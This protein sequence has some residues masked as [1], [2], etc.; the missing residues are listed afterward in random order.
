MF[1]W[2]PLLPCI[3]TP[4]EIENYLTVV[5]VTACIHFFE[6]N[7]ICMF[8]FHRKYSF[9]FLNFLNVFETKKKH[10]KLIQFQEMNAFYNFYLNESE[11]YK[12]CICNIPGKPRSPFS[13]SRPE[14]PSI[15]G[16]PIGP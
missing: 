9:Q 1:A 10:K 5:D 16:N 8:F 12:L 14:I 6:L 13:P 15:P 2:T 11:V 4:F 3:N 7:Q